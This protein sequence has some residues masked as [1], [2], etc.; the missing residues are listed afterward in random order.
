MEN[1][2]IVRKLGSGNFAKVYLAFHEPTGNQVRL[3]HFHSAIERFIRCMRNTGRALTSSGKILRVRKFFVQVALKLIDKTKIQS[4][5]DN[6]KMLKRVHREI[7]NMQKLEHPN[8]VKLFES[9]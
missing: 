2:H 9:K 4:S 5:T 7:A 1:Y 6:L 8:T 3:Q